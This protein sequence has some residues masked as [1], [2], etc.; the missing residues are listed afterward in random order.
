MHVYK[1]DELGFKNHF[2]HPDHLKVSE[3]PQ[4]NR[5][6]SFRLTLW[7]IEVNR[8]ISYH[9]PDCKPVNSSGL[10][11]FSPCAVVTP[12]KWI[13]KVKEGQR[14]PMPYPR[15]HRSHGK[16]RHPPYLHPPVVNGGGKFTQT[17]GPRSPPPLHFLPYSVPTTRRSLKRK[18]SR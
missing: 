3:G 11:I 8:D 12:P 2:K 14:W 7:A 16:A 18:T 4:G 15:L 6:P 9:F 17:Q 10:H 13:R 5:F 1:G